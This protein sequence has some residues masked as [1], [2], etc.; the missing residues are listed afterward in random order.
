MLVS[1]TVKCV[2]KAWMVF[3]SVSTVVG[4][5]GAVGSIGGAFFTILVSHFLGLHPL[6][7]F[8][9]AAFA[10][11]LALLIFQLLVPV[12]GAPS[13]TEIPLSTP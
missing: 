6:L 2:V 1:K 13:T 11:L 5:G 12:L 3:V 9:L 8:A 7:I 10:Y 4:I